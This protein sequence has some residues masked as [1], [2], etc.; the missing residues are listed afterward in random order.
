MDHQHEH[1][2]TGCCKR[3]FKLDLVIGALILA[4]G[5]AAAS[6]L[7]GCT[8]MRMKHQDRYITVK[9]LS[10]IE[11]MADSA[12]WMLN[13]K[14]A[15]NNLAELNTKVDADRKTVT[16]FLIEQ[17]FK[18][19]EIEVGNYVVTDLLAQ[20]YRNSNSE[21]FRYIINATIVLRT[22]NVELA[23]KVTQMKNILVQKGVALTEEAYGNDGISY[24]VT[25]LN[26]IKP[27]MLKEAINNAKVTAENIVE[28]TN[29]KL[30]DLRKA[31]QGILVISSAE[32]G[33]RPNEYDN[34][35]FEK[36]SIKKKIRLVTT[37]E[38]YLK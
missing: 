10:E 18:E 7:M 19:N 31:N 38:Y 22:G 33:D 36:K 32:G 26:D 23:K 13:I 9:G 17:G 34:S 35:L 20:T 2:H 8:L 25:K 27:K 37:L 15:G 1:E 24:E 16:S 30:G 21:D 11:V 3:R 29:S 12:V 28:N 14:S 6:Y 5:I 4:G